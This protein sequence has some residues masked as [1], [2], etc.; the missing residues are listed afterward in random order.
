MP[1]V[2]EN[3]LRQLERANQ[4]KKFPED[5]LTLLHQP[6]REVRAHIPVRMDDGTLRVFEGYRVEYNNARGP[7]KGGIRFHPETDINEVKALAFWMTLKC[8]VANL[9]MGGDRKSVT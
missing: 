6:Q 8:A 2:F 4:V 3:A 5:F 7:Y 1:N 9:P